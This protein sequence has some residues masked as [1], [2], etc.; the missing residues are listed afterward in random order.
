[1]LGIGSK[2][3][4]IPVPEDGD[5][6]LLNESPE[7]LLLRLE[8]EKLDWQAQLAEMKATLE[9]QD[10]RI[11]EDRKKLR[12]VLKEE[13]QTQVVAAS[14]APGRKVGKAYKSGFVKSSP[15]KIAAIT[16]HARTVWPSIQE[17]HNM[18]ART[19]ARG[20]AFGAPIPELYLQ[21][22]NLGPPRYL[23]PGYPL[24]Y[25]SA[26]AAHYGQNYTVDA[27]GRPVRLAKVIGY[28]PASST[29]SSSRTLLN[30][31]LTPSTA[32]L[33]PA[34]TTIV[35]TSSSTVGSTSLPLPT[36]RITVQPE[37]T[38]TATTTFGG[39]FSGIFGSS[40][41]TPVV[42]SSTFTP[43]SVQVS[44]QVTYRYA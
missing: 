20:G 36:T 43:A 40:P 39:W 22:Y 17:F 41:S 13:E 37:Q 25:P 44:P 6:D 42:Q 35:S 10:E 28:S 27:M 2:P 26:L 12:E 24:G 32:P 8:K 9:K 18:R 15:A 7:D 30:S 1:M 23:D 4:T 33:R 5:D 34:R 3:E 16:E 11:E 38:Q 31:A 21:S 29:S 19:V 14:K